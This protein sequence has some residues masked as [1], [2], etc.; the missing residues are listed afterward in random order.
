MQDA[1]LGDEG[2]SPSKPTGLSLRKSSPAAQ[3]AAHTTVRMPVIELPAT[4]EEHGGSD[5]H[6][7]EDMKILEVPG[8]E[9][10][11]AYATEESG[12]HPNP[13]PRN[14]RARCSR[15]ACAHEQTCLPTTQST[16]P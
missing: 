9:M 3:T 4:G 16:A 11:T 13:S 5:A 10:V 8:C 1:L 7:A 15:L 6:D 12:G 2:E 14:A